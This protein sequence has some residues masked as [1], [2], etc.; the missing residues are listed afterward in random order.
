[1]QLIRSQIEYC[2]IE[3]LKNKEAKLQMRSNEILKYCE[4][5]TN[6]SVSS[7]KTKFIRSG[8]KTPYYVCCCCDRLKFDHSVEKLHNEKSSNKSDESSVN[9]NDIK[10]WYVIF[11]KKQS[12]DETSE[13][14][15]VEEFEKIVK[16]TF[17][18]IFVRHAKIISKSKEYQSTQFIMVLLLGKFLYVYKN[19]VI[20]NW[21]LLN[22]IRLTYSVFAT[23]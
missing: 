22:L 13:K 3:L 14:V 10:K 2:K 19:K 9:K 12:K 18:A 8:G 16:Y 23:I 15:D 4:G 20:W 6:N 1:M 21:K 17:V 11:S 5:V 7:N